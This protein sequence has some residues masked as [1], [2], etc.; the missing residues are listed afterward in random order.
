MENALSVHLEPAS[1]RLSRRTSIT[2]LALVLLLGLFLRAY[3][4]EQAG[5]AVRDEAWMLIAAEGAI[6]RIHSTVG[7]NIF[8][9]PQMAP[10]ATTDYYAISSNNVQGKPGY[11]VMLV[12]FS[13]L[14]HG[15]QDTT[16]FYLS[17]LFGVLGIPLVYALSYR[18]THSRLPALFAAL[19][20]ATSFYHI[21]FSRFVAPFSPIIVFFL[22][23]LLVYMHSWKTDRK[24]YIFS[25]GLLLG[26]T[27]SL[28]PSFI[29]TIIAF[30]LA[31][32][33]MHFYREDV[34]AQTT[35]CVKRL[36]SLCA[37][38]LTVLLFWEVLY[39]VGSVVLKQTGVGSV[40]GSY[41]LDIWKHGND[42]GYTTISERL[43]VLHWIH[44]PANMV[45]LEGFVTIFFLL[46]GLY[47]IL[48]GW[49]ECRSEARVIFFI[50]LF[51]L[52]GYTLL[53]AK[54]G[55]L[56]TPIIPLAAVLASLGFLTFIRYPLFVKSQATL[57]RKVGCWLI[58]GTIVHNVNFILPIYENNIG[59]WK[60]LGAYLLTENS[61]E[62]RRG[63]TGHRSWPASRH[64]FPSMLTG[65]G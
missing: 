19:T 14:T 25:T 12:F 52:T 9:P 41:I 13:L 35:Q 60:Q 31:E 62:R 45:G 29:V 15:V 8:F 48:R 16:G 21:Y 40:T 47:S 22:L 50:F 61:A 26:L 7:F 10:T 63:S 23:S 6:H 2:L 51:T 37:G 20:F 5:L 43:S 54:I 46:I 28:H 39:R 53:G 38:I 32:A 42:A 1:R 36:L 17:V 27:F 59:G 3:K 30:V 24:I 56:L 34:K 49:K 33:V 58:L 4:V 18:I 11:I 65:I 44:Y 57:S 64:D 55:R